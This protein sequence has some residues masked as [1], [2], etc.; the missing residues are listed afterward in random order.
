MDSTE[1]LLR[2][3]GDGK[4]YYER[5]GAVAGIAGLTSIFRM[6]SEDELRHADALRALQGGAR[7]ELPDSGTLEGAKSILRRLSVQEKALTSFNGD[8]GCYRHAMRFEAVSARACGKLAQEAL[9]GWERELFLRIAAEDEIHFT[10]LEHMHE[11]LQPEPDPARDAYGS[12]VPN[13]G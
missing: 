1:M 4:G 2:K 7:V 13:A 8:L 9:N 11:L 5:C 6:F 10:L 3:E 12:G